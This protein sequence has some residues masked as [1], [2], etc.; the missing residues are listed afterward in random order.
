M[1]VLH[2]EIRWLSFI[3]PLVIITL[4]ISCT[5][6][7]HWW[8]HHVSL[9]ELTAARAASSRKVGKPE[10]GWVG[11]TPPTRVSLG[12]YTCLGM[13]TPQDSSGKYEGWDPRHESIRMKMT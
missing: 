5:L 2:V 3:S 6:V 8:V 12:I 10:L 7:V 13:G 4:Y 11:S 1:I 9:G